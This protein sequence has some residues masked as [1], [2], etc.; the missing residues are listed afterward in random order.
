MP[1]VILRIGLLLGL[2]FIAQTALAQTAGEKLE[3][4]GDEIVVC[5]QLYH[6]TAPVKLWMDPE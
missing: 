3:R 6:T 2:A 4:K 5:G 1:K